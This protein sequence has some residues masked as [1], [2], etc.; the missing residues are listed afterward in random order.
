MNNLDQM[1][2]DDYIREFSSFHVKKA[3]EQA[4]KY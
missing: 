3:P 1:T 2:I 4:R